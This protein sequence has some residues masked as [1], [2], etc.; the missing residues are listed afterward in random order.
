VEEKELPDISRTYRESG[1]IAS[2]ICEANAAT[3]AATCRMVR[4]TLKSCLRRN[5]PG[6]LSSLRF[7]PRSRFRPPK[8]SQNPR[9]MG[10][11]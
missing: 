3:V 8:W 2:R 7:A 9:K 4:W 10:P 5:V 1:K 6:D 11:S